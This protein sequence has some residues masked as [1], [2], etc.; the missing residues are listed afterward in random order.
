MM[1][2]R[3]REARLLDETLQRPRCWQGAQGLGADDKNSEGP[4][5]VA[6]NEVESLT[7]DGVM[8]GRV[9]SAGLI[10]VPVRGRRLFCE[11]VEPC[12]RKSERLRGR[13]EVGFGAKR[14]RHKEKTVRCKEFHFRTWALCS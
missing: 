2:T 5:V 11:A 7:K 3:N 8:V 6:V 13:G 4:E 1:R 12:Q 9:W 14:K 10:Q